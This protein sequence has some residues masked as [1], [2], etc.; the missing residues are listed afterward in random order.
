MCFSFKKWATHIT[1]ACFFLCGGIEY[2]K[3]VSANTSS[4]MAGFGYFTFILYEHY[5]WLGHAHAL[6]NLLRMSNITTLHTLSIVWVFILS[7]VI[8]PT[9]S[10]TTCTSLV[11][12]LV[13][14]MSTSKY[15]WSEV[16]ACLATYH[17]LCCV[18]LST[19]IILP[20][21]LDF[22]TLHFHAEPWIYGLS[23][24]AFSLSNLFAGPLFGFIYDRTKA[25]KSIVLVANLFE[26]G[27]SWVVMCF[28]SEALCSKVRC[29]HVVGTV[30]C[31]CWSLLSVL[32]VQ[33]AG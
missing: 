33:F 19:G 25:V 32:V 11:P 6:A 4:R 20:T 9:Y 8:R 14:T 2:G 24:S 28:H 3:L 7:L 1:V 16:V 13:L 12:Y 21:A 18:A 22:L 17:A 23:L 29:V 27:G 26:I 10:I 15:L 30:F 31:V 5:N